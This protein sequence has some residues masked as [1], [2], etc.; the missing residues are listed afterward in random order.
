MPIKIE[1]DIGIKN[2]LK[3]TLESNSR[4]GHCVIFVLGNYWS[5]YNL[6]LDWTSSVWAILCSVFESNTSNFESGTSQF[7]NI[8]IPILYLCF[9]CR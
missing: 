7:L 1:N 8:P 6:G 9:L 5:N 4:L 3:A 2:K